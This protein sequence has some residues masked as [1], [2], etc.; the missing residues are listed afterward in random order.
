MNDEPISA[1]RSKLQ[2]AELLRNQDRYAEAE[3]YLS[4]AITEEPENPDGYYEMAFCYCNWTGHSSKALKFIDRAIALSPHQPEFFA[5]RAW[6]LVNLKKYKKALEVAEEALALNPYSIMARNAQVRAH[7]LTQQWVEAEASARQVLELNA[8]NELAA[9]L[10]AVALRQQG[11]QQESEAVTAGLLARAPN[12]GI[13]HSNAGWSALQAGDHRRANQHFLEALRLDPNDDNAR[14][15]LLHSF[16]SRVWIYR[17]YFQA[18]AEI[19]RHRQE[20]RIV[21]F[22]LIYFVYR[23][24]I[25]GLRT[26]FGTEGVHWSLVLVAFYLVLFGFGKSFGNFF[27]LLDPFARH[28][29]KGKEKAWALFAAFIYG[30]LLVSL[31]SAQAWLQAGV[32]IGVVLLFLWG[33]LEPRFR[34]APADQSESADSAVRTLS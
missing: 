26:E 20:M 28:A 29:L 14:R 18:V 27:L 17:I 13:A 16:N 1:Y 8:H 23:F 12:A 5:L 2:R 33:V 10:L 7:I 30:S 21:F 34:R 11:R 3:K 4:D 22:V 25:V 15:G 9:N 31:I 19:G 6:I 24:V 32:L